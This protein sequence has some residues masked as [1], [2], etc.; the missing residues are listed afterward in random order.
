MAEALLHSWGK[1]IPVD[2]IAP[3]TDVEFHL[4]GKISREAA[5][6]YPRMGTG[7][8]ERDV[9]QRETWISGAHYELGY[10]SGDATRVNIHTVLVEGQE[11]DVIAL[12]VEQNENGTQGEIFIPGDHEAPG[13]RTFPGEYGGHVTALPVVRPYRTTFWRVP[14][15]QSV[16]AQS[17][18]A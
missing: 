3:F 4:N 9:L 12:G 15:E 16:S 2:Q 11:T 10:V 6:N 8:F 7:T 5:A 14:V 13:A 1:V 17:T 18:V